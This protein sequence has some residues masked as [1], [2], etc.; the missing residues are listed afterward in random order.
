MAGAQDF[1][2]LEDVIGK[3]SREAGVSALVEGQAKQ[4]AQHALKSLP[5]SCMRGTVSD[6][7]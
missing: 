5:K 7:F 1:E 3:S 4:E 2:D 6:L